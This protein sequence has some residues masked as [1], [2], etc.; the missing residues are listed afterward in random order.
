[1]KEHGALDVNFGTKKIVSED[2]HHSRK[3]EKIEKKSAK[4]GGKIEKKEECV[5]RQ[6]E[7]VRE[8]RERGHG[9]RLI[10]RENKLE[11]L[12]GELKGLEGKAK[13]LEERNEALGPAGQRADRDFRKQKIMTFRT[14]LLE[15]WL[16][17]FLKALVEQSNVPVSQK[18]L[19][20]LFFKRTGGYAESF[21][22]VVYWLD[23]DGLSLVNKRKL[24]AIAQAVCRMGL[25]RNGKPIRV[26]LRSP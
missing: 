10:Q 6:E 14:L 20:E 12:Q 5:A 4:L 26:Q 17:L 9:K 2:R 15:N 22:Q 21:S 13:S 16:V 25:C 18:C 19:I 24:E 8:S 11:K 7:K 1:M 23:T 3:L